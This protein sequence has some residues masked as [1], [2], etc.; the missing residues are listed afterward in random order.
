MIVHTGL[1]NQSNAKK[2]KKSFFKIYENLIL[3]LQFYFGTKSGFIKKLRKNG[4]SSKFINVGRGGR[5][6]IVQFCGTR[7]GF[8]R[9]FF[10]KFLEKFISFQNFFEIFRE[11]FSFKFF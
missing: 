10:L 11:F 3:F 9:D 1:H 4:T 8:L 6:A 5:S 7:D 2:R